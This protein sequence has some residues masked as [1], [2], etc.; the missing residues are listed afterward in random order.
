MPGPNSS[1]VEDRRYW[2]LQ[3]SRTRP[4]GLSTMPVTPQRSQLQLQI[5]RDMLALE[6]RRPR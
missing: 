3:H 6:Y 4:I 1:P 5:E 2:I